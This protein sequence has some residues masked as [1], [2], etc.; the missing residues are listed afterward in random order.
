MDLSGKSD[1]LAGRRPLVLIAGAGVAA[2][3]V[4]LALRDLA[5]GR[6]AI[7]LLSPSSYFVHRPLSVAQPFL[8]GQARRIDLDELCQEAGAGHR[9]GELAEVDAGEHRIRT[10][11]GEALHYE[12]LVIATGAHPLEAV[13][14]AITFRGEPDVALLRG[15]L[16]ELET[17]SIR[18][19][20]FTLPGGTSW[21]LPLY[22][23][24][25][26]TA[27][28]LAERQVRGVGITLATPEAMPLELFG[29]RASDAVAALLAD[30]GIAFLPDHYPRVHQEGRLELVPGGSLPADR[31]VAMPRLEGPRIPGVGHDEQGF[32][33]TDR[34]GR[35]QRLVDVYAAGDVTS[36]P[37][38]QGGLA[39]EQAD[40]VAESLAAW[41]GVAV[42]PTP[43]RPVLRGVLLAGN[44]RRYL[45][46]DLGGGR[47]DTSE[48]DIR[49]LWWP[50]EKIAGKYLG[51][52]LSR[53]GASPTAPEG[54]RVEVDLDYA[55]PSPV[56]R[57]TT[58]EGTPMY[59]RII[60][61]Y[62]GSAQAKDALAL[63]GRLALAAGADIV[64]ATVYEPELYLVHFDTGTL[65]DYVREHA[66]RLA[67]EASE[68][69]PEHVAVLSLTIAA[70]S[71]AAGL[72]RLAESEHAD[73]VVIGSCHRGPVGRI[74]LGSTGARV[75]EAAPCAVAIAPHGFGARTDADLRVLATAY[76]GSPEAEVA[77]RYAESLARTL[78][79]ELR[80]LTVAESPHVPIPTLG[81]GYPIDGLSYPSLVEAIERST[82]VRLE[83]AVA[84]LPQSVRPSGELLAGDAAT[85]LAT[86]A[87][88][89][90]DL[91]VTGSRG[92][93]PL[94]RVLLGSVSARLVNTAPCPVLVVPRSAQAA[95]DA[96]A[97]GAAQE[98]AAAL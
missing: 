95:E 61:G 54:L 14:G 45:R 22:E 23:L 27:E 7:E 67:S 91:L 36:F 57:R 89:G 50:P 47:G 18:E 73:L 59:Q 87:E 35:V 24:A 12:A 49:A 16:G 10:G 62:D 60:V 78:G 2:L 48:A 97:P 56:E 75:M 96:E 8:R 30:R 85:A 1:E 94:R 71:P 64:V 41:A 20:V 72:N 25:L 44:T 88:D 5:G 11:A 17:G 58:G 65:D 83:R 76:D 43:F 70:T 33:L 38:K 19:L 98:D 51:P 31:V 34:Y 4:M 55:A 77:L 6:V 90:V 39:A 3:E 46:T 80:V 86:A 37:V 69:L 13:P 28:H 32:I 21:A 79:S 9:T 82:R 63:A 68:Q 92:Y 81:G 15:L 74:L 52:V 26:M 40:T 93:G 53:H 84:A 66:E 29:Q 42:E